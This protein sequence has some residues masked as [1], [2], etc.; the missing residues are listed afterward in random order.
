MTHE[1][2]GQS[3]NQVH[4]TTQD[5][6]VDSES[7][8]GQIGQDDGDQLSNPDIIPVPDDT[9]AQNETIS[10]QSSSPSQFTYTFNGPVSAFNHFNI[11]SPGSLPNFTQNNTSHSLGKRPRE[12]NEGNQ[13]DRQGDETETADPPAPVIRRSE[14]PVKKSRKA[15]HVD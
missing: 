7:Q 2:S 1:P 10:Q 11:T 6:H 3:S 4:D 8:F 14:R 13:G 5:E 12:E 15:R 9:P